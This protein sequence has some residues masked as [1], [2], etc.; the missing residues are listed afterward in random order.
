[1]CTILGIKGEPELK[2][3]RILGFNEKGA[4]IIRKIKEKSTLIPVTKTA[5]YT[6]DEMFEKDILSTDFASLCSDDVSKRIC[7]MDYITS[8]CVKK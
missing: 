5:D 4:S 1:M 2:Y 7:G 3:A 6:G 8:P